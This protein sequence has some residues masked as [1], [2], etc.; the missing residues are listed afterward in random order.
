[1]SKRKISLVSGEYFHIYNRGN[2]KQKIFL[3]DEDRDR[4]IK[5][6][7]LSNS[8]ININFRDN[9][10]EAKIDVW[11]FDRGDQIV[12]IGAWV[13]MP[14]HF[15]LYLISPIPGIGE[16]S[17]LL[18]TLFMRKL[19][20]GYA[21]YFNKKYNRTGALFEGKF[22]AVHVFSDTQ[23][24]YLFSYIHLNPIKLIDPT[25]KT[26]GIKDIDKA[27]L[28]LS[29]YKWSSYLDYV[30]VKRKEILILNRENFPDYFSNTLNF[31][32]EILEWLKIKED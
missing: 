16:E 26:L 21:N 15:H 11:D 25:W 12:S 13:L 23:A 19:C 24:K 5:L 22:K 31:N 4:F 7:Y 8:K 29:E 9:I 2:S 18:I 3:D 10:V 27:L 1:M 28:F 6:L 30:G 14:N 20:V 32:K 17:E